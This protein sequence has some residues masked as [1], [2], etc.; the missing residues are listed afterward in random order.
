MNEYEI[1]SEKNG[2]TYY[3]NLK[4]ETILDAIGTFYSAFGYQNIIQIRLV[5]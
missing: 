3:E 1:K 5:N 2:L 4:G